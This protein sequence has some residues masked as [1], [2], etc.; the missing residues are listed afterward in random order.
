MKRLFKL[1]RAIDGLA[2]Q[3]GGKPRALPGV[4]HPVEPGGGVFEPM[5]IH[6]SRQAGRLSA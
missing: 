4:D 1:M 5:V 6:R 2:E 3:S